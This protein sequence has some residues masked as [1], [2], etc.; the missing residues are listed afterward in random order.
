M[1]AAT[2]NEDCDSQRAGGTM[3]TRSSINRTSGGGWAARHGRCMLAGVTAGLDDC[4]T[5]L[6]LQFILVT[7]AQE[8]DWRDRELGPI[9]LLKY[10]YLADLAH[11]QRHDGAAYTGATWQFYHFGPWQA[12][13]FARI[14]PALAAI[15]AN[16]KKIPSRYEGD[17]IRYSMSHEF[18]DSAKSQAEKELPLGVMGAVQRAVHDFGADTT[19]LLHHTYLTPPMLHAAPGENLVLAPE[20]SAVFEP[21]TFAPT[22][23][24]RS[25]QRRRMEALKALKQRVRQRLNERQVPR[26]AYPAPR[27]DAVFVAGTDWLDSLAGE[28]IQTT[29]GE[30]TVHPD[31]WKSPQ[32]SEPDVP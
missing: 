2:P 8:D 16:A 13:V 7:A 32:R 24:S 21:L 10:A 20:T 4:R 18:V 22:S 9:H 26:E 29:E 3:A 15:H 30:V 17:F 5:D 28:P 6:L 11:A 14:E 23:L 19:S 25:Q 1:H 31:I 12:D 27:Y